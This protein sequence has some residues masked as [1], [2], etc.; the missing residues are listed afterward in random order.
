MN[1]LNICLL[2]DENLNAKFKQ[3]FPFLNYGKIDM[4]TLK[5]K[6]VYAKQYLYFT[7]T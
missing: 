4:T 2:F 1:D 5:K 7:A 6:H 3:F